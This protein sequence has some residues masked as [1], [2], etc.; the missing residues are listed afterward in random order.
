MGRPTDERARPARPVRLRPDGDGRPADAGRRPARPGRARAVAVRR[1]RSRS[2]EPAA[3][4]LD[5]AVPGRRPGPGAAPAA[6]ARRGRTSGAPAASTAPRCSPRCAPTRGC[7]GGWSPCSVRRR[8]SATT[9]S[10]TRAVA[11]AGAPTGRVAPRAPTGELEPLD[12]PA[13]PRWP[14]LRR[15]YRLALLRIAAADLT[16]GRGAGADHGRAV[17]AGRRAPCSAAYDIAVGRAAGGTAAPR[18]AVVAMGK[19][20]GGELNYVSD[21]DVI[22]VAATDDDL[23]AG[24]HRGHPADPHLRAGRLAGR[25]RA[26]PGGQ[27]RPAGPDA[28]PATSPTTGAGPAPGSSRRCSR[29]GRRPATWRSPRSGS[30]QLAPLVWHAAERPEAVE[31]VRAMRRRIID[32]IPPRELEREI[33]RGPGRA[34]RHRVRRAAAAAGARPGRR[35]AAGAGHHP[36]AAGA[37]R[38]AA[39]SAGPTVRRCCA[40][41]GS[42]ARVEHRLQLQ[43]LRRTHTVPTEPAGAALAGRTRWATPPTPGRDA[44]EAFRADWVTHATEV[45]RLH[46]KLLY[47]PLLEAVARVPAEGLRLTPEA[48]RQPAG[49]PRLRRPG[50]RAAAPPGAHRRGDPHG[51]DPAHPAA[52]AAAGVRRRARAGPRAA[53]LPAGL[54]QARQ[55]ALVPAAAARRGPG[56]PPAGPGAGPV[57]VRGRPAGP[58]AGGAAAAGRGRRA[59]PARRARCSATAS[60]AAAANRHDDDPVEAIRAV[61]ALRRRELFRLACADVLSRAGSLAPARRRSDVHLRRRRSARSPTSPTPRW[62]PRCGRPGRASRRRPGCASPSSGW[63][64]SAGTR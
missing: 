21:V 52:G 45:R 61:R 23:P 64:G 27:P 56:G 37:G 10:P 55:H 63:A 4:L 28:W 46:A 44:V 34:A 18:L 15:A 25:R 17:R 40:A 8:R 47:R 53:Q 13:C 48:A 50:R 49:D 54:R 42:C 32:N 3:E 38:P 24:D 35:V 26:A 30:T 5:R 7:G 20:G 16:G 58:R 39:T 41:T 43:G 57:P 31:D 14:A 2:D 1:R 59:D 11:R 36:G 19:C 51:G 33:K 6:P 9:W 62:P 29:P 60:R 12:A 22:F